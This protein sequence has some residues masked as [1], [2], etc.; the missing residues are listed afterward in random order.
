MYVTDTGVSGFSGVSGDLTSQTLPPTVCQ[1][2]NQRQM[3]KTYF[4]RFFAYSLF[5][6]SMGKIEKPR[7]VL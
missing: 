2:T 3:C 6:L 4:H 1:V 7:F 5:A